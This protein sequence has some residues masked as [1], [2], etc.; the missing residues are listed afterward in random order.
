MGTFSASSRVN[1]SALWGTCRGLLG[2]VYYMY[3]RIHQ[4]LLF[5]L[6][7]LLVASAGL[8]M[9]LGEQAEEHLR[10]TQ[11]LPATTT[12]Y[13]T[14][15]TEERV[16]PYGEVT[17]Q[18]GIPASK[19]DLSLTV[20]SVNES[21][22][23]SDVECI[24]AGT[25]RVTLETV[26]GLGTSTQTLALGEFFTTEAERITFVNA[27][28]YPLSTHEVPEEAYTFRFKIEPHSSSGLSF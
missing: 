13:G 21:R 1:D 4:L 7:L 6:L 28:P 16:L 19:S 11:N 3:M 14:E 27:D 22:C 23:P 9:H 20:L 17:A 8:L 25:V 5:L 24:Q 15:S 26:S 10:Q 2:A 18:I 12:V